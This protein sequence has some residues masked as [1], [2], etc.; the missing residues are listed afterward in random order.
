VIKT[1]SFWRENKSSGN[2]NKFW[3]ELARFAL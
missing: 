1:W 2:W 3:E